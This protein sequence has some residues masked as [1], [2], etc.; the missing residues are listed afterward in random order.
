MTENYLPHCD[1]YVKC[2][3]PVVGAPTAPFY[4]VRFGLFIMADEASTEHEITTPLNIW[5]QL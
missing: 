1:I 3:H 2:I 4:V 5:R